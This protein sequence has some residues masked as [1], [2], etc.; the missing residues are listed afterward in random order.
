MPLSCSV[1]FLSVVLKAPS[2]LRWMPGIN[3]RPVE[4]RFAPATDFSLSL[5]RGERHWGIRNV[6]HA[7]S[8]QVRESDLENL[9][10]KPVDV[11]FEPQRPCAK[12]INPLTR[13]V[14]I[15]VHANCRAAD[16]VIA[17][18]VLALAT[19]L[20]Q[21]RVRRQN[22]QLDELGCPTAIFGLPAFAALTLIAA[23]GPN[24]EHDYNISH[25]GLGQKSN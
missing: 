12:R 19:W 2:S 16:R 25:R 17:V 18:T 24:R 5:Y 13:Q 9:E 1:A 8:T 21:E 15:K 14:A 23:M 11:T 6:S 4:S 3:D 7:T 20:V 10:E 22:F